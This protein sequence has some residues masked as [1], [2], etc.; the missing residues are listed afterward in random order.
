[1]LFM[2]LARGFALDRRRVA[3]LSLQVDVGGD[4]AAAAVE[5]GLADVLAENFFFLLVKINEQAFID[6]GDW[7]GWK[8]GDDVFECGGVE[9]VEGLKLIVAQRLT[10][11]ERIDEALFAGDDAFEIR[12]DI[13]HRLVA[14]EGQSAEGEAGRNF[15][16]VGVELVFE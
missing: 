5:Q 1:M 7:A 12:V 3:G 4:P 8:A 16:D 15:E 13:K 6:D 10:G 9:H 2:P 14:A 11:A